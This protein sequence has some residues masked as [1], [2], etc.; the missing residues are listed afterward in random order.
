[1]A[2]IAANRVF[3]KAYLEAHPE[4]IQERRQVLLR[5]APEAFIAA[6]RTLM[7]T[8]LVPELRAIGNPTLVICGELDAATPP[9]LCRQMADHIPGARYVELARCG[10]C[11]P[12]EQPQ[13][14][15]AA[16]ADF[17]RAG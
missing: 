13:A 11:P 15:I 3:H 2:T 5:V 16:I 12:L 9:A 7:T 6:C 14:F 4:A 8:D 10:H 1:V 17:V